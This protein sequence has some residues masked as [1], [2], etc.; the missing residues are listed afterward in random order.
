MVDDKLRLLAAMKQILGERLVT[1]FA[2]QGHYALDPAAFGRY[3]A[4]DVTVERIGQ[5][6]ELDLASLLRT[7]APEPP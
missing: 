5:L 7:P 3:P 4:S 6:L 1:V 2:R